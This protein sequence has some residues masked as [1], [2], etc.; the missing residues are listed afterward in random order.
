MLRRCA[1]LFLMV[2]ASA[3]QKAPDST[4]FPARVWP[5]EPPPGCP[6]PASKI[7]TGIRFTGRYARYATADTWYPGWAADG[8]LYSPWTDGR[9]NGVHSSSAGPKAVTGY[10]RIKGDNPLNLDVV[11]AGVVPGSPEPYGG[12][13]PSASLVHKGIW[14][15]GTYC[16][17]DTDGDPGKGLN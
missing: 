5:S 15:Y 3:A 2:L 17:M 9:V 1:V 8:N 12:R 10:A 7:V 6:F 11:D 13:Y 16:L 14:Y 4:P